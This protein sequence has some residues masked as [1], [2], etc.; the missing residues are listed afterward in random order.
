LEHYEAAILLS[1]NLSEKDVD[2]F[3]QEVKELLIKHGAAEI[4]EYKVE[5]RA[6]AYPIK[7]HNE[8][9]YAFVNFDGPGALPEQVRVELRHREEL[10]RL[11]FISK[12]APIVEPVAE[13]APESEPEP[14]QEKKE[15]PG[16]EDERHE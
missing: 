3:I 4:G 8:G 11:A 12:P 15:E 16:A 2:K 5:R 14:A 1:P 9:F 13:V 10:L 6:F 7:K